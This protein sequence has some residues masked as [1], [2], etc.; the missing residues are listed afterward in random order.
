VGLQAFE[1]FCLFGNL[2]E[3]SYSLNTAQCGFLNFQPLDWLQWMVRFV[4]ELKVNMSTL[5]KDRTRKREQ[6]TLRTQRRRTKWVRDG[7]CVCERERNWLS[8]LIPPIDL[9]GR[10]CWAHPSSVGTAARGSASL[11]SSARS[12]CSWH[13]GEDISRRRGVSSARTAAPSVNRLDRTTSSYWYKG[14]SPP[15]LKLPEPSCYISK[16]LF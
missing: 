8:V 6:L 5:Y 14:I 16:L 4:S 12:L 15:I 11:S 13:R 2:N 7:V 3:R 1:W 9:A 10:S